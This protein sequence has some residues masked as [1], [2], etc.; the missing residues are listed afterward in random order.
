MSE[1]KFKQSR[2]PIN[3][4]GINP[5]D[6]PKAIMD[7]INELEKNIPGV[8]PMTQKMTEQDEDAP[9]KIE[10]N[11]PPEFA[12]LFKKDSRA[13]AQKA[14]Q[15]AQQQSQADTKPRLAYTNNPKLNDLLKELK[16]TIAQ[17]EEIRLPS[18]SKFYKNE[19]APEGGILHV[20]PMTGQEE[21]ILGTPRFLKKG[22]AINMI[23]KNCI[24][25]RIEPEKWLTIDRTHLLIYLRGI[26]YG[27]LYDV[28]ILCP[29]CRN[30]FEANIDLDALFVNFCPKEFGLEN[31]KGELPVSKFKF[32][33]HLP[34]VS[35]ENMIN[36]YRDRRQKDLSA[37]E[38][39]V[40]DT[41]TWRTALLLEE[42]EGLNE[43][44]PLMTLIENLPIA[45]VA[46]LRHVLGDI[47]FG[48][49]TKIGQWCPNCSRDF[50]IELPIE[51]NFFFPQPKKVNRTRLFS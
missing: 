47:P 16:P 1:E 19:E 33:W 46:H 30:R 17:F 23:F 39:E 14:T 38:N 36:N 28:E 40:D 32:S 24:K 6:D 27:P 42:I 21:E 11:V 4:L 8:D 13:Q 18:L 29:E 31:L 12:S 15:Q 49:D 41:F 25:E 2:K 20:R 35:D 26:S 50:E 43:H 3:P 7:K 10:G 9:F 34:T 5:M 51:A 37:N 22:Q 48:V 45:D 44:G